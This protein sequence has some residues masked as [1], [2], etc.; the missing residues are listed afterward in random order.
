MGAECHVAWLRSALDA[1]T[2]RSAPIFPR[3][4]LALRRHRHCRTRVCATSRTDDRVRALLEFSL[5][6]PDPSQRQAVGERRREQHASTSDDGATEEVCAREAPPMREFFFRASSAR[7]SAW[8][9]RIHASEMC[10]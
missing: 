7:V 5:G 3:E 4:A 8:V 10:A 6:R 9:G 2:E 1:Q